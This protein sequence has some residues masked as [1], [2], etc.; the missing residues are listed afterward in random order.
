MLEVADI[1]VVNKADS[2]GSE[3]LLSEL[4][5]MLTFNSSRSTQSVMATQAINNVGVEELYQEI[6][7]R[8]K[9]KKGE[10]IWEQKK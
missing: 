10:Q 9:N 8:Y 4:Q 2:E 5:D 7:K 1:I 3:M 6:E